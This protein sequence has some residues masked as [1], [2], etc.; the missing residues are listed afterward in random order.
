MTNLPYNPFDK[1]IDSLETPDL[2]VL[3]NVCEGWYIEYK[4]APIDTKKIAKSISAFSNHYG[5]WLFFGVEE[6]KDDSLKAGSYPGIS[7]EETP[8]LVQCIKSA[9]TNCINPTPYYECKI[10]NGPCAE[11]GLG[12]KKT[13]IVVMIPA[14]ANTPYIHSDARIY[15]RISDSSSPRA[16]TDKAILDQLW[17]RGSRTRNRLK[18]FISQEP[19]LTGAEEQNSFLHLTIMSDPYMESGL[20]YKHGFNRFAQIMRMKTIPFDNIFTMTDGFIAR[21]VADNDHYVFPLTWKFYRHG[22]SFLSIPINSCAISSIIL[23]GGGFLNGYEQEKKFLDICERYNINAGLVLDVNLLYRIIALAI[24]RHR[25]LVGET[26]VGGP[27]YVKARLQ[28]IWRRIPFIDSTGYIDFVNSY[29]IPLVQDTNAFAPPGTTLNCCNI[30]PIRVPPLSSPTA[31]QEQKEFIDAYVDAIHILFD[32]L[33]VLGI[34][35]TVIKESAGDLLSLA[36]R[37]LAVQSRRSKPRKY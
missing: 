3:K 33:I 5:G 11:I 20:S 1:P 13:I 31:E 7:L 37:A 9:V 26:S 2:A 4:S 30:L 17:E 15:R 34:P 28:N 10:L 32:I 36:D 25:L 22:A 14:G 29:G 24:H 16:E 27:F 21:Q 23:G 6:A 12:D 35:H 8:K 18:E 19:T